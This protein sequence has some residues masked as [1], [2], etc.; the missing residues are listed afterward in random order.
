MSNL[1]IL[2]S[3]AQKANPSTLPPDVLFSHTSKTITIFDAY[4]KSIFHFLILPRANAFPPLTVF[5]LANLRTLMKK[6]KDKVKEVLVELSEEAKKLRTEIEDEMQKRYGFK[7]KIWTGFHAVPSMEH[8]HLHVLSA[9][10]CSVSMKHKK[11]YNSFHPK[12]GFFQDIDEVL[13]WFDAEPSYYASVTKLEKSRYEALLK[14]DLS[15]FYCGEPMKNM[16]KLKE[17]LQFEWDKMAEKE[18][19]KVANSKH[20]LTEERKRKRTSEGSSGATCKRLEQDNTD[21]VPPS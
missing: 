20:S 8:L 19:A 7:W 10:L 5:D 9:D 2:R 18:K 16:P 6:D 13:S 12:L 11:H 14:S 3:Y 21:T 1:T 17:H 4:P 15:C